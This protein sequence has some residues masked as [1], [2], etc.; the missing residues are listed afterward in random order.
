MSGPLE[1]NVLRSIPSVDDL[2]N[3][4]EITALRTQHPH[5]PWTAFLRDW[6]D[7]FRG[8]TLG[9]TSQLGATGAP[10]DRDAIRTLIIKKALA[11]FEALKSAGLRRVINATGVILNTNL[12]RATLGPAVAGAVR[13]AMEH[14][15]NLEIDLD[16]GRRGRRAGELNDMI[17]L[18]TGAEASM[19]VNNNAAAVYLVVSSLSPPGRVLVSR[20]ELVEIGGSFRLPDILGAAAGEVIEVGTT[21][22]TYVDDYVKAAKP[23]DIILK[24]HRSNYE[25]HGF[26]HEPNIADL[27]EAG[28]NI[29]CH[30]V[31]DLGSGSFFDFARAGMTGEEVV[32]DVLQTGVDCVTMS[33]DKLLGGVQAGIIV[34]RRSF[35][36]ALQKNPLRRAVRVDKV[37]IAALQALMRIYLFAGEP[38]KEIPILE[39][40]VE[41]KASQKKRAKKIV[42]ALAKNIAEGYTLD[43]VDD[44]AVMGGGS[45]ATQEIASYAVAIRCSSEKAAEALSRRMRAHSTP[46]LSRIKG[47]EVRL[48]LRSVLPNEDRDVKKAL[49][50]ILNGS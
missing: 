9:A 10:D 15:V 48:N 45:F 30:V 17:R 14:Y 13:E 39:Q 22:R 18:A 16:T 1:K 23:G 6:V 50:A 41:D 12:G 40:T 46:V 37:T 35:L 11:R 32:E 49:A 47:E 5:F 33:G 34:G 19:V 44:E 7:A 31:Y 20:G 38:E 4:P 42:D 21:N 3:A 2:L 24:A 36:E 8:G 28:H 29:G 26:T 43:V 25:I 27:V